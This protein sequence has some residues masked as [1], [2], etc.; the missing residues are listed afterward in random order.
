MAT[1]KKEPAKKA[2]P[3]KASLTP[4]GDSLSGRYTFDQTGTLKIDSVPL[5]GTPQTKSVRKNKSGSITTLT[6]S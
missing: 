4:T 5:N 1:K 6:I 2:A 3:K